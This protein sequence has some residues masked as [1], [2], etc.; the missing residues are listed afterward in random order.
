[1]KSEGDRDTP[2][3]YTSTGAYVHGRATN[4]RPGKGK[5][6]TGCPRAH[7]ARSQSRGARRSRV[8]RATPRRGG[9]GART[10]FLFRDFTPSP[11]G[12]VALRATAR[13]L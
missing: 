6:G 4:G 5:K 10:L 7:T 13:R 1:M 3:S 9:V 12:E 2:L 11:T 8:L